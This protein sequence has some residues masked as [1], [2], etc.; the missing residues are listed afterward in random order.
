MP[1][2]HPATTHYDVVVIGG[3]SGGLGFG[4]RASA[5]YGQKVA[6]IEK[7]GKLGGTCVGPLRILVTV[8]QCRLCAQENHVE[9]S[10]Y[11]GTSP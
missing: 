3:G 7:S 2:V 9:Y 10:G 8:G 1:P 4:R 6:V 5:L 11:G